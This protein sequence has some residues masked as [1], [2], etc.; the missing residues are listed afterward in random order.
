MP[1]TADRSRSNSTRNCV[2]AAGMRCHHCATGPARPAATGTALPSSSAITMPAASAGGTPREARR[3]TI[4]AIT[5]ASTSAMTSGASTGWAVR[6]SQIDAAAASSRSGQEPRSGKPRAPSTRKGRSNGPAPPWAVA[7]S[8]AR[9]HRR[10]FY[11]SV[12]NGARGATPA[13]SARQTA[14]AGKDCSNW[15]SHR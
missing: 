9:I 7:V 12:V 8:T 5:K 14:I 10:P 13:R 2:I 15:R 1:G 11:G 6:S 4:G 3:R